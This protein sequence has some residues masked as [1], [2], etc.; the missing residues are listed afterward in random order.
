MGEHETFEQRIRCKAVRSVQPGAGRLAHRKQ[1]RH[2]GA[3][4]Q[5]GDETSA[6]VMC[7]WHDR[8]RLH[9]YVDP[10]LETSGVNV[11]KPFAHESGVQM[12]HVEVHVVLTTGFHLG[13]YRASNDIPRSQLFRFM[14]ARHESTTAKIAQHPAFTTQRLRDQHTLGFRV[15]EDGGV[16]LKK[17]HVG[18]PGSNSVPHRDPVARSNVGIRRVQVHLA[19]TSRRQYGH[20]GEDRMCFPC[21]RIH[22]VR[23][24]TDTVIVVGWN[25]QVDGDVVLPNLHVGELSH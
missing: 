14:V 23:P 4:I 25:N 22:D 15:V 16:E 24:F 7:G 6:R 9:S 8:N 10:V 19:R 12:T 17:L 2:A 11:G 18:H 3:P 13:V 21:R 1:S 20:R 5:I